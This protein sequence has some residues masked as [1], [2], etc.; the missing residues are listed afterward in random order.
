MATTSAIYITL[1]FDEILI[2]IEGITVCDCHNSQNNCSLVQLGFLT[3]KG[4][5]S[6]ER[7]GPFG[8]VGADSC[9]RQFSLIGDI[10][11]FAG[12]RNDRGHEVQ[13]IQVHY[14]DGYHG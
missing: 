13:A 8:T 9:T 6:R 10:I 2:G 3:L 5:G 1:G 12:F 4:D 11:G 14:Y 7:Y